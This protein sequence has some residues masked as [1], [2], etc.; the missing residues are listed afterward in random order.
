[1]VITGVKSFEVQTLDCNCIK[2]NTIFSLPFKL[3]PIQGGN[4]ITS[5]QP[6]QKKPQRKN[7]KLFWPHYIKS[8]ILH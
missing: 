3:R 5:F 2:T 7:K 1:M 8:K 4:L 6:H